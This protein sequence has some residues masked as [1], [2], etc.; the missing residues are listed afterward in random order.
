MQGRGA[1]KGKALSC[2]LLPCRLRLGSIL[3]QPVDLEFVARFYF[4]CLEVLCTP[5][6]A[7]PSSTCQPEAATDCC[8]HAV[9]VQAKAKIMV[10]RDVERDDIEYIS[11]TLGCLPIAHPDHMKK[12]KL[13]SA[14]LVEEVQVGSWFRAACTLGV[15][16]PATSVVGLMEDA[17]QGECK[18]GALRRA[19][20]CW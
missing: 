17:R 12:E 18:S 16:C 3:C 2:G 4:I 10:V 6:P 20:V 8:A 14:A 7:S 13:G 1:W 11:K 19:S 9:A 5:M 15:W